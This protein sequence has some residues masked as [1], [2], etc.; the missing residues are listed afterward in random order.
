MEFMTTPQIA[1]KLGVSER[2]VKELITSGALQVRNVGGVWE[3]SH[4]QL[5]SLMSA[6]VQSETRNTKPT[7]SQPLTRPGRS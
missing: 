6:R 2:R 4:N 1:E 7:G 3:V 5:A